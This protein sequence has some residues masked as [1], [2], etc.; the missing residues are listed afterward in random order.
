MEEFLKSKSKESEGILLPSQS[1]KFKLCET[2]LRLSNL[3]VSWSNEISLFRKL[4][5]DCENINKFMHKNNIM[6]AYFFTIFFY[7]NKYRCL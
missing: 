1:V 2:I 6:R 7:K 4:I 5:N 3:I